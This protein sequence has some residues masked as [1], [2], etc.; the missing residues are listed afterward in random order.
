MCHAGAFLHLCHLP[1]SGVSMNLIPLNY[2]QLNNWLNLIPC[3]LPSVQTVAW[4][5]A[6][7]SSLLG[8]LASRVTIN[9]KWLEFC[10]QHARSQTYC[11]TL[12][13]KNCC[14]SQ[15][16]RR[17]MTTRSHTSTYL[18][19]AF[20]ETAQAAFRP[21]D[22]SRFLCC[23]SMCHFLC[24]YFLVFATG[25]SMDWKQHLPTLPKMVR[26]R[27]CVQRRLWLM[28]SSTRKDTATVGI[29][30]ELHLN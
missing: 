10:L 20:G 13:M 2:M 29:L 1:V 11:F 12:F 8:A 18:R 6:F 30:F 17:R 7:P 22:F 28:P 24:Y 5:W 26:E 27:C 3:C 21:T 16:G 23:S 19:T 25:T 4:P 9:P 14:L 15:P